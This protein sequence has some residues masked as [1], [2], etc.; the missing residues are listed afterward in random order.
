M[1]RYSV[2]RKESVIQKMMPPPNVPIPQ[3]AEETGL[4][5]VTRYHWRKQARVEGMPERGGS[6]LAAGTTP[7][8]GTVA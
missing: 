3:L 6:P 5:E 8:T 7:N 2:E 4:S 1:K